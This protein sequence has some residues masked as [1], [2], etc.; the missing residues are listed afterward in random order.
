MLYEDLL[1]K[2]KKIDKKSRREEEELKRSNSEL[3]LFIHPFL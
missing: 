2:N 1:T 3:P